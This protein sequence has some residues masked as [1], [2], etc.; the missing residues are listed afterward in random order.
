MKNLQLILPGV[1]IPAN[2]TVELGTV[3]SAINRMVTVFASQDSPE[4]KKVENVCPLPIMPIVWRNY[5]SAQVKNCCVSDDILN[6]RQAL[7]QQLHL[8]NLASC[9]GP[10]EIYTEFLEMNAC[11]RNC[12]TYGCRRIG[13]YDGKQYK[14]SPH[15]ACGEN[16][17][18]YSTNIKDYRRL[19]SGA[20]VL[21]S[22]AQCV[23]EF[24]PSPG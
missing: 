13:P 10:N 20:C 8:Y 5:Q 21:V 19:S 12:Q 15:C 6:R 18:E 9:N 16:T 1:R 7:S 4:S 22:D 23:A 2:F 17:E 3:P 11:D 14:W 24:Q